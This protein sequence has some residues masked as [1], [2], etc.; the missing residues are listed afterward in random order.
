MAE[1]LVEF[2]PFRYKVHE[3]DEKAKKNGV[4][5]KV[6]G[7]FQRADTKNA[8]GRVY[9]KDLW[10]K[11]LA[12]EDIKERIESKQMLGMFGH[13][14][15]GQ[16]DP[17]NISHVVTKQDLK[18]D[19][20]IYGEAEILDTPA[21]RIVETLF[22]AGVKLGIS[23]R[24]DGSVEK[25]GGTDEVQDDFRLETYDF[26]L[27]PST[28]GAYPGI[29][30]SA[31][32]IEH[33]DNLILSAISDLVKSPLPERHRGQV[34]RESQEILQSLESA[35]VQDRV[36]TTLNEIEGRLSTIKVEAD[37]KIPTPRVTIPS[38][39]EHPNTRQEEHMSTPKG[40]QQPD[41]LAWHQDQVRQAVAQAVAKKN[42]EI[43]GLK[44]HIVNAQREHAET[45][46]RLKAAE[47][48]IEDFQ[49]EIKRMSESAEDGTV[50][51]VRYDAAKDLLNEAL[52]R[53]KKMKHFE[54][55]C[56]T[57]EGLVEASIQRVKDQQIAAVVEECLSRV[58]S[59]VHQDIRPALEECQ[60]PEQVARTFKALVAISKKEGIRTREPLP[61]QQIIESQQNTTTPR[62]PKSV[63]FA[64][65][66]AGRL[67]RAV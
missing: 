41:T 45:K 53:L 38:R 59:D 47:S 6:E 67:A 55:R 9:P 3:Q 18:Q 64:G 39:K 50:P 13:P 33:Q 14:G 40:A 7:V 62:K 37:A 15:N 63:G 10:N 46:K 4:L 58:S 61:G 57:L 35:N 16:T 24:G 27:K 19:G 48:V 12:S 20:T 26:V 21:G 43:R 34:L 44:D 1:A 36:R 17:L 25:K 66:L 23:S 65:R 32:E 42:E 5:L 60:T 2:N 56:A 31:Q 51:I 52:T 29:Q 49:Y 30:E 11:V 22:R 54:Q 8:N 28:P